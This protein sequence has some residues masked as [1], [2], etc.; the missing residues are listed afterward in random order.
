[1]S[2]IKLY[3]ELFKIKQTFL[4]VFSGVLG[5][6]II[7]KTDINLII[8]LLYIIASIFSICGTTGVNM[9]YD[10]DIDELM[11]RTKDRPL[12]AKK[13][14]PDEAYSVSLIL[15]VLGVAISFMI[16]FWVGLATLIGFIVD[17]YVYTVALKRRTPFNIVLGAIA[18]GMPL[19]GG[20]AAYTGYIDLTGILL[21]SIVIIW[22]MLHIWYI[23]IY[24]VDDY[25]K[26]NVPMLPVVVG[27]RK[28]IAF[29][30][31]GLILINFIAVEL[32][33]IGFAKIYSFITSILFTLAIAVLSL[34]YLKTNNRKYS[35]TAYKVLS[36]Y[37]GVLLIV[38]LFERLYLPPL[39]IA[40]DFLQLF[41]AFF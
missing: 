37:L 14:L 15:V 38:I 10:R 4:L 31:L 22:A 34:K 41:T 8:L 27:E 25:R 24:Y 20:Y 13:I 29:S 12:P 2:K 39:I 23:A 18:G 9:Y 35:R 16:N 40:N 11:F 32:W 5:Y 36:P 1:M 30:I 33:F 6:L 19:L 28:T 17:I 3:L 7:A 21:S 26:A